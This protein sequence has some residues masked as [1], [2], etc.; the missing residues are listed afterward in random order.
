MK[1]HGELLI[2]ILK[3]LGEQTNISLSFAVTLLTPSHASIKFLHNMVSNR[4]IFLHSCRESAEFR[5]NVLSHISKA[6][7]KKGDN[8]FKDECQDLANA[9]RNSKRSD[10][11]PS[12]NDTNSR[13]VRQEESVD[14]SE[15]KRKRQGRHIF[16]QFVG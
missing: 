8:V 10:F 7:S 9:I 14:R 11:V 3:Y 16:S 6:S 13:P 12:K 5:T 1:Q 2:L 15:L 4:P